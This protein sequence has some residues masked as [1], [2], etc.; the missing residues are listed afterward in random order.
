MRSGVWLSVSVIAL[1]LPLLGGFPGTALAQRQIQTTGTSTGTGTTHITI[2]SFQKPGYRLTPLG[3][4]KSTFEF[5][6]PI[7][8]GW[9]CSTTT[10]EIYE[11]LTNG[12]PEDFI[13]A[14]VSPCTLSIQK[15][16]VYDPFTI[17]IE[18]NTPGQV[19]VVFDPAI[20]VR[21]VSWGH[22]KAI[23]RTPR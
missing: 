14:Y 3:E 12:L 4:P 21:Q 23:Y 13:I 8:T 10:D 19:T 15:K 9:P 16:A 18:S 22:V 6:I 1:A 2:E 17:I 20:A 7:Q 5:D 11:T